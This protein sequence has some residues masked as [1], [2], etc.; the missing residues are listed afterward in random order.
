MILDR[1]LEVAK[2]WDEKVSYQLYKRVPKNARTKSI[3]KG[4]EYSGNGIFWLAGTLIL[5]YLYP[6]A[7]SLKELMAGFIMDIVFVALIKAYARRRRPSYAPQEDQFGV[8]SVDKH[9]FPS[10]HA[11][12]CL[13]LAC[14]FSS[15]FPLFSFMVWIWSFAVAASRVMLGR[16]H[17]TDV[18]AGVLIGIG[19]YFMQFVVGLPVYSLFVWFLSSGLVAQFSN[20]Q[21]FTEA[22]LSGD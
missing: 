6:K 1:A 9:S 7:D 15:S 22:K 17:V 2:S 12:R 8:M 16:H 13:Y 14:F 18:I 21:D 19:N 20:N 10:G 3:L 11:T 4:L 5:V